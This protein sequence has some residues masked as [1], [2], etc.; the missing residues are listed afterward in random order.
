MPEQSEHT[1]IDALLD[2]SRIGMHL[3]S[4]YA[5]EPEQSTLAIVAHHPQAVYFGMKSGFLPK[6]ARQAADDIIAGSHRDP[7]QAAVA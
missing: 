4:G 2:L 3:T 1:K 6:T 7:T 5:P